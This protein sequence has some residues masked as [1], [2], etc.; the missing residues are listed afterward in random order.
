MCVYGAISNK[1][2]FRNQW[3]SSVTYRDECRANLLLLIERSVLNQSVYM[4]PE[5]SCYLPKRER[6]LSSTAISKLSGYPI[7]YSEIKFQN[8]RKA[9]FILHY[10]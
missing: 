8:S 10:E 9:I 6:S 3:D 5:I 2:V 7:C 1:Y 4:Y